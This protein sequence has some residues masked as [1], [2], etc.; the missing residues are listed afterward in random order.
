MAEEPA[1]PPENQILLNLIKQRYG[2]RL[3]PAELEEVQQGVAG[4]ARAVAA[5]R[6]VKLD[7]GDEP[8]SIFVPYGQES[9]R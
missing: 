2:A 3:T 9:A 1:T 8:F 5:L 4:I 6:A 7:N